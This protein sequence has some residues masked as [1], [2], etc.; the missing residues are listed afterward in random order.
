MNDHH[1][2]QLKELHRL[3]KIIA[4][5][6]A[7]YNQRNELIVRLVESGVRQAEVTRRL[8]KVRTEMGVATITPDAVAATMRRVY[9]R[10]RAE[11]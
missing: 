10:E 7:T 9:K 5:G 1:E 3:E 4:H 6:L 8:N 11:G 2:Q